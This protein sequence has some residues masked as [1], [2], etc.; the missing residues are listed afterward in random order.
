MRLLNAHTMELRSFMSE[1]PP[2]AILSHC[3]GRDEV[4]FSDLMDLE[5]AKHKRGFRKIA[6][7]CQQTI[8]DGLHFVWIDSC[9]IDK[10]S[11]AELSEAIN[12]MFAWY[13]KSEIC[14]A[15]LADVDY[16]NLAAEHR[17]AWDTETFSNSKWFTRACAFFPHTINM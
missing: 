7:T 4:V 8:R 11:S 10:S 6:M 1:S 2:Y 17:S 3:W 15:F 5:S 16:I 9:C 14:Y 13:E 12:S